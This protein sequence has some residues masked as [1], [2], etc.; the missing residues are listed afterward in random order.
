MSWNICRKHIQDIWNSKKLTQICSSFLYIHII[1]Y[2]YICICI[3]RYKIAYFFW[4]TCYMPLQHI[5]LL[6]E[7]FFF[8]CHFE[9]GYNN[10]A[11][12][13]NNITSTLNTV[14]TP[15][16]FHCCYLLL[17]QNRRQRKKV[18]FLPFL[19][20]WWCH[21]ISPYSIITFA[22]YYFLLVYNTT[23]TSTTASF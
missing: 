3:I 4:M 23:T 16:I 15:H 19:L 21:R 12:D 7:T 11:P 22:I 6:Q 13:V 1:M 14:P 2:E 5:C 17:Q 18:F 9:E 8:Y 10:I 20:V